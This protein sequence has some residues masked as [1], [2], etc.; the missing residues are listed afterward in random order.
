M[1]E[2]VTCSPEPER[3]PRRPLKCQ[4]QRDKPVAS[5][6]LEENSLTQ[7]SEKRKKQRC[8]R[9]FHQWMFVKQGRFRL[10]LISGLMCFSA[11]W[12]QRPTVEETLCN[13]LGTVAT[14]SVAEDRPGGGGVI[15]FIVCCCLESL[16]SLHILAFYHSMYSM[17][18]LT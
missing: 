2:C 17:C 18:A 15:L 7:K 14:C 6:G 12:S 1:Y 16:A 9:C 13:P 8:L 11:S 10:W 4:H 5:E 3:E